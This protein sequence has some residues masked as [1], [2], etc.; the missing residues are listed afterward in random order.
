MKK[1]SAHFYLWI[2]NKTLIS[3]SDELDAKILGIAKEKLSPSKKSAFFFGWQMKGILAT[4]ILLFMSY[5]I[6]HQMN[7]ERDSGKLVINESPEMIMNYS[8]I[9][10]MAEASSLSEEDWAKIE[11]SK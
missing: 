7:F 8:S 2:K 9:E 4:F 11:R 3:P 1:N 6:N 5:Q 10:L